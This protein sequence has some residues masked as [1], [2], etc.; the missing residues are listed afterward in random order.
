MLNQ[1][2]FLALIWANYQQKVDNVLVLATMA[3]QS[4]PT[5]E[6]K[7]QKAGIAIPNHKSKTKRTDTWLFLSQAAHNYF[8]TYLPYYTLLSQ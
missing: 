8:S 2:T 7:L 4:A 3:S 1:S 5:T 6:W